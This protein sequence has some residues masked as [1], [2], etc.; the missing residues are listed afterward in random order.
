[1]STPGTAVATQDAELVAR[2][3]QYCRVEKR[4]ADRTLCL[5]AL[6]LE[7]LQHHCKQAGLSL[8]QIQA[9]H[10]RSWVAQMRSHQRSSR[11]IALIL[12]GWRGFFIWAC[13][14]NLLALNPVAD[15]RPP[16]RGTPLP[17]ALTVDQAQQ[18]ADHAPAPES[19]AWL[20]AR[21]KAMVELLYG[22]G[23]RVAELTGLDAHASPSAKGW[24]DL[25]QA[26]VFVTGK[27]NKPRQV[28]LGQKAAQALVAW[29]QVR[30]QVASRCADGQEPLFMGRNGSRLSSQSIWLRLRAW[31]QQAGL[32]SAVHPHM[33]RHSFASH[34][35]QS[36]SDLRA[37]QELL[38][39][40]AIT[41][42]QI[43]T[44]LDFQHLSKTYDAA[45][46]RAKRAAPPD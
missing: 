28:P 27:G 1:M 24:C 5:Y 21:D 2:Y 43:Y 15:I 14:Q 35:L 11:G 9:V 19:D 29:L 40:A 13:R 22:C 16:K 26:M 6:D 31:A 4:L 25:E 20:V 39:H 37:V 30:G 10:I 12:S 23:L 46:P 41:T 7:K 33:L 34:L 36:S 8:L 38:G 18:L 32:P 17:K 3:L 42:T 45:H 44:R